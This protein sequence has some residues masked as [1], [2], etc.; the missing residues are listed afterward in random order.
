MSKKTVTIDNLLEEASKYIRE[1]ELSIIKDAYLFASLKHEG[2]NYSTGE[3]YI[4][5]PLSVSYVLTGVFAD[6]QSICA[7]LLHDTVICVHTTCD[8]I[9]EKFGE[10]ISLLVDGVAK[11]TR[12]KFSTDSDYLKE[13]YKKIIVGMSEDVRVIIIKLADAVCSMRSLWSLPEDEQKSRAREILNILV[14]I[15]DHLGIHKLKSELE[16]LSLRYL[17]PDVYYEIAERLNKTKVERENTVTK[18][19]DIVDTIMIDN[20][21]KHEI[22]GRAK[23]IY[24]IYNKLAKGKNFSNIYD[25]FGLRILVDS[26]DDCYIVLGL[27]HSK[28]KPMPNRFK[29]YIA[30][31]KPNMYQSLHTTVFGVDGYLFEIQIRT[32]EMNEIAENGIASHWSYKE[33]KGS[34]QEANLE[35]KLEQK[36]QLFKSIYD[37][38]QDNLTNEDFINEVE[39]KVLNRDSIYVY[40]PKGDVISLPIGSTPID[41]AYKI[42]SRV[43]DTMIGAIANDSIV[44]LDYELQDGDVVNIRT[45]KSTV[46]S[47][48][49]LSMCKLPQTKSKIKSYFAKNE[50]E[51]YT[52]R[53]KDIIEKELR[54]RK[55]PIADFFNNT[56]MEKF[57]KEYKDVECL[58]D[59]Y[60]GIGNDII[61]PNGL[62]NLIY[63]EEEVVDTKPKVVKIEND[64]D[65]I[66]SGIDKVKVNIANCCHPVMGDDIIGFITKGNGITVHRSICHNIGDI[67]DRCVEVTWNNQNKGHKYLTNLIIYSNETK[68]YMLDIMQNISMH[69]VNVVE[70]KTINSHGQLIYDV[71][72]Y[73]TDNLHIDKIINSL[74]KLK[75]ITNVERGIK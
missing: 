42:H 61:S 63:K 33:N 71:S 54:K 19:K 18:M 59:I 55:L 39:E 41:F 74:N 68:S 3:P 21:I 34:L 37:L 52:E 32:Y 73:V 43:G 66:V 15:G 14:P 67:S 50:K 58:E 53:G 10:E 46:P 70:F 64:A 31:P 1:D 25:L 56:N 35:N 11:L 22:A 24:S 51:I 40:T 9:K 4:T 27:I 23:S 12:L 72:L 36:L 5:H 48:E 65:I 26:V 30:M 49:W 62:I 13:Y 69:N 60:L 8:E 17:K 45:N 6:S 2:D 75:F 44:P 38:Q 47:R 57:I 28:F 20:N 7:G 29:D 16:D